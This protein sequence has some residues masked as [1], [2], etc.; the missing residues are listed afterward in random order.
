MKNL[1][2]L[3]VLLCFNA[4]CSLHAQQYS[5]IKDSEY[6]S[7]YDLRPYCLADDGSIY[8]Y[9]APK[10]LAKYSVTGYLD[11]NFGVNGVVTIPDDNIDLMKF[12]NNSIYVIISNRYDAYLSKYSMAG[13]LDTTF[14]NN[15]KVLIDSYMEDFL[16]NS[17]GSVYITGFGEVKKLLPNG[18]Y[19]TN[20]G[21]ID[22]GNMYTEFKRSEDDSL[23]YFLRNGSNTI[24]K[25]NLP[26][27]AVDLT[28]GNN[29]TLIFNSTLY[30]R[31]FFM[32]K[33]NE[34]FLFLNDN[35][36]ITKLK[37]NGIVDDTFGSA[38]SIMIDF[39]ALIDVGPNGPKY[40]LG[41]YPQLD[42]DSNSNL[43]I[44]AR[45]SNIHYSSLA[46][47]R[48][49]NYGVTDN[50]FSNNKY[51]STH[52]INGISGATAGNVDGYKILSDNEYLVTLQVRYGIS[53][54]IQSF[55]YKRI[56]LLS[57]DNLTNDNVLVYPNPVNNIINIRLKENEKLN[58]VKVYTMD[59]K[60]VQQSKNKNV[61]VTF[62]SVGAYIIE[63]TTNN[64]S[65]RK[66]IIKQ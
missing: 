55:K 61:S 11:V 41:G 35:K 38:G 65:Y 3:L 47:L 50:T 66:K 14:G 1:N 39:T 62:L 59:G 19:D 29:G 58:D 2:F 34:I 22:T 30:P 44:F 63:I 45:I 46:I 36:T 56:D 48:F 23:I 26:T 49:N 4:F 53:P 37:A 52:G 9:V 33:L 17:D 28:F 21:I 10:K 12:Y 8:K 6:N 5:V 15:G 43:L 64:G 31:A 27:G 32:N 40:S 16:V 7:I 13:I 57:V 54:A 20:F 42:F 25:K 51:F 18:S 24:I 60:L